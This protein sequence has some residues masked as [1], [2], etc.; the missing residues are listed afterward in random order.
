[1]S[2]QTLEPMWLGLT[3]AAGAGAAVLAAFGL[4]ALATP[5]SYAERTAKLQ[6]QT[7]RIE[8]LASGGVTRSSYRLGAVCEG[9]SETGQGKLR[10]A[11]ESAA[12]Q[13]NL[14][15][16]RIQ[17]TSE[18]AQ[19]VGAKLAPVSIT[20]QVE[21]PYDRLLTMTNHLAQGAPQIFVDTL[22]IKTAGADAQLSLAGRAFCWT[23][24]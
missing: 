19:V 3:V 23:Q 4:N 14:K 15:S 9:F 2:E 13:E 10:Q 20:I 24:G 16:A 11:I 22:D 5:A 17:I 12:A 21:G 6:Q 1:M 18:A 7:L 8:A